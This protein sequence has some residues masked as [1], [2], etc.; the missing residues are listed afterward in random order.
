MAFMSLLS[1]KLMPNGYS[2][3]D[4]LVFRDLLLYLLFNSS[5]I[6]LYGKKEVIITGS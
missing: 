6:L 2:K 3:I 1:V 5:T 4:S